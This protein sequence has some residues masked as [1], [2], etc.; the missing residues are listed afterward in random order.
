MMKATTIK[1]SIKK[2]EK[3]RRDFWQTP[4]KYT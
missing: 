3:K 2:E 1:N 4:C